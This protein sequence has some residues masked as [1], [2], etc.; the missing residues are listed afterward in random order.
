VLADARLLEWRHIEALASDGDRRPVPPHADRIKP[1]PGRFGGIYRV[2]AQ[3]PAQ[4][5]RQRAVRLPPSDDRAGVRRPQTNRPPTAFQRGGRV[6]CRLERRLMAAT[7]KFHTTTCRMFATP[8]VGVRGAGAGAAD[9]VGGVRL[10]GGGVARGAGSHVEPPNPIVGAGVGRAI[11]TE[12]RQ[13]VVAG[14]HALEGA[15][16]RALRHSGPSRR[17]CSQQAEAKVG[18]AS[19]DRRRRRCAAWNAIATRRADLRVN[20][21][22]A[23]GRTAWPAMLGP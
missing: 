12:D 15:A 11:A 10:G 17:D 18:G 9:A 16:H 19:R 23:V 14:R 5:V 6:A 2:D 22:A 20:T 13:R 4:Q 7:H 21:A 1:R 8:A 3:R